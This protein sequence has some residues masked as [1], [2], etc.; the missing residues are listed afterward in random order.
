MLA[1]G[2]DSAFVTISEAEATPERERSCLST[3]RGSGLDQ[4][5]RHRTA[6]TREQ[7]FRLEKEYSKESYVSR[8][9][10]CELA[11]A[12]N[13]PETTI[14]VWFQNRRMKDKRQRQTLAWPHPLDPNVYAYVM[15]Q[16]VATLPHPLLPHFPL[17]LYQGLRGG[18]VAHSHFADSP[19]PPDPFH[20]VPSPYPRR[21]LLGSLPQT[22]LYPHR[23]RDA[24]PLNLP[25]CYLFPMGAGPSS[26]SQR[27]GGS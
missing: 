4:S 8:P 21:E 14:K 2:R 3:S 12:L 11:A 26:Q 5:R 9:R 10:R 27:G 7:L 19:R 18:S 15:S 24:A 13:L 20:L 6:F 25:L 23:L 1:D 16:A 17:N 22:P